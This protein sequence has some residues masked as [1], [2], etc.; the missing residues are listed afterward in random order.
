MTSA[1]LDASAKEK[2]KAALQRINKSTLIMLAVTVVVFAAFA[3]A[4]S[5]FLT[6]HNMQ[7]VAVQV[8]PTAIV[9]VAMTFVITTGMIDLS[10]GS[11]LALVSVVGAHLLKNGVQSV[12]V[13]FICLAVGALCGVVNG[14]LSSYQKMPSFIVTLATMSVI[15]GVALLVTMGY[16]VAIS[17]TL[18]FAKIGQGSVLGFGNPAWIALLVIILG[19]VALQRTRFGQYVTGVGSN[20]ESVRRAGVNTNAIKMGALTISGLAAG[21]AG[22]ITAG[23]LGSGDANTATDFALSVITAV[24]IGGTNLL[25]GKGSILGT[26]IGAIL[27][28]V[29]SDG[30]TLLGLS[31]YIV[32]IVTGGLLVVVILTN[33]RSGDLADFL[34]KRVLR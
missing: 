11:I 10:V 7:N 9:A 12:L 28:G 19:L 5:D 14:Y 1:V 34:R 27:I 13:I 6:L 8:A 22:I 21:L 20:E 32:P 17:P 29:I 23:R 33:L 25:G 31:P 4:S 30:L 24:V 18:I 16:S 2:R 15:R 26:A 3:I